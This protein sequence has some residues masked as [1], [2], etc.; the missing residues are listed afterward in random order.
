M[1]TIPDRG[2]VVEGLGNEVVTALLLSVI[3]I[4]S[5]YI[6]IR[7]A[8]SRSEGGQGA[9]VHPDQTDTVESTRRDLGLGQPPDHA[10]SDDHSTD[11]C[12]VC[13]APLN[14][15]VQTNCGHNFCAQCLLSYWRHDQW[16]RPA[17]CPVCRRQVRT[18][19]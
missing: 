6:L 8:S 5:T 12:P 11:S 18:S 17:R 16:P 9:A 7:V 19:L 14:Y 10:G 15:P 3:T 4:T 13:L 1:A 2:T